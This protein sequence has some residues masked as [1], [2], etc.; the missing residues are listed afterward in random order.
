[1]KLT[2]EERDEALGLLANMHQHI[3]AVSGLFKMEIGGEFFELPIASYDWQKIPGTECV[4]MCALP[5]EA[6]PRDACSDTDYFAARGKAGCK[7]DAHA[8]L[9]QAVTFQILRGRIRFWKESQPHYV[10][11]EDGESFCVAPYERHCF[12]A[13]TDFLTRMGFNPRMTKVD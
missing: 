11:Y 1:M 6:W 8:R 4:E 5:P 2:A 13:E 10:S 3:R 7:Q 12:I 9:K